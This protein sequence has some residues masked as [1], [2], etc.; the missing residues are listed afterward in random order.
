MSMFRLKQEVRRKEV[1]NTGKKTETEFSKTVDASVRG[2]PILEKK[3]LSLV[4]FKCVYPSSSLFKKF[5]NLR[6]SFAPN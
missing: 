5:A 1:R 3:F 2:L 4:L 6:L